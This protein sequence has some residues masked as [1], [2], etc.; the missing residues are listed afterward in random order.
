[1]KPFKIVLH[2]FV[3]LSVFFSLA[4]NAGFSPSGKISQLYG[5]GYWVLVQIDNP[6]KHNPN[7]CNSDS[8]Y[9]L[10]LNNEASKNLYSMLLSAHLAQKP[11]TFWVSGCSGQSNGYPNISSVKMSR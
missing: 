8:Y 4:S 1:M 5:N 2:S 6:S 10:N 3:I 11:V 9:A 7:E